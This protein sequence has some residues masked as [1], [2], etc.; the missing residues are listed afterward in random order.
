MALDSFISQVSMNL[1]CFNFQTYLNLKTLSTI[2]NWPSGPLQ[3][4]FLSLVFSCLLHY[5][6]PSISILAKFKK[7]NSGLWCYNRISAGFIKILGIIY[8]LL[9]GRGE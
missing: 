3:G 7:R 2:S 1:K 5:S 6:M 8:F 4:F 9:K